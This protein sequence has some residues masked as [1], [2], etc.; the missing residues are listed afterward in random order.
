MKT[1]NLKDIPSPFKV[2]DRVIVFDGD[3]WFKTGDIGNNECFFKPAIITKVRKAREHPNEWLADV[4]FDYGYQSKG[5]FQ[6]MI[7]AV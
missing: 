1:R 3:E 5:H 2:G 4:T 6:S 7:K